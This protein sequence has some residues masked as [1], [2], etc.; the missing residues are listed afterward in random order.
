MKSILKTA[1][2]TTALAIILCGPAHAAESGTANGIFGMQQGTTSQSKQSVKRMDADQRAKLWDSLSDAQKERILAKR[3]AN[4]ERHDRW[5]NLTDSAK[6][7]AD[8]DAG[9][10]FS[11]QIGSDGNATESTREKV[12]ALTPG[13]NGLERAEALAN[14]KELSPD[15][16]HFALVEAKKKWDSLTKEEQT[17]M[18]TFLAYEKA[19]GNADGVFGGALGVNGNSQGMAGNTAAPKPFI[20]DAG[21]NSG[22]GIVR[23]PIANTAD[24]P[25]DVKPLGVPSDNSTSA[26]LLEPPVAPIA[27]TAIQHPVASPQSLTSRGFAP[28]ANVQTQTRPVTNVTASGGREAPQY[29]TRG[30]GPVTGVSRTYRGTTSGYSYSQFGPGGALNR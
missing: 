2:L 18:R 27:N 21:Q 6:A 20:G 5:T 13:D 9:K 3:A 25:A 26:G 29:G 1:L 15:Q 7:K 30:R 8:E 16:K 28:T 14:W 19:R 4:K 12:Q 11:I 22:G 10:P 24:I 23:A 17:Q